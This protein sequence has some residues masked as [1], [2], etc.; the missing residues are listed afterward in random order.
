M[1]PTA[2]IGNILIHAIQIARCLDFYR[3]WR[4]WKPD[5]ARRDGRVW[6]FTSGTD[7]CYDHWQAVYC[8][9]FSCTSCSLFSIDL[10]GYGLSGS[11]PPEMSNTKNYASQ[12]KYFYKLISWFRRFQESY[13]SGPLCQQPSR[14]SA[15][16]DQLA[17]SLL[18]KSE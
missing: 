9:T 15:L 3:L 13:Y 8:D 10:R 17:V 1:L 4:H 2:R 18:A 5:D 16:N 6:N 11:L 12:T 14:P 7:P